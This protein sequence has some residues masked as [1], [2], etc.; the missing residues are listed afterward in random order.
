MLI[1]NPWGE[2]NE[3]G[4]V[5]ADKSNGA[6]EIAGIEKFE[7]ADVDMTPQLTRLK[8]KG[9]DSI[10]LVVNTP[11]GAQM[12][13]SRERMGWKVPVGLALGHLRRPVS[14]ARRADRGRCA[15]RADLQLLRQ[16]ERRPASACWRR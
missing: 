2:S 12:M 8:E 14:R 9:A 4:L 13:K 16:A 15:L 5:D 10:I 7:N 6:V 3:K 11:P 1:N